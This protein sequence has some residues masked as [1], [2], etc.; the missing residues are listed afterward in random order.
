[1]V[2]ML[3]N[4]AIFFCFEGDKVKKNVSEDSEENV[5]EDSLNVV[6]KLSILNISGGSGH[7]EEPGTSLTIC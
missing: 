4:T 2:I 7:V 1:M 6:I 5:A 3:I